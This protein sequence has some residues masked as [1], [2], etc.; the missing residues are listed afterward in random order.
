MAATAIDAPDGHFDLVVFAQSFHHLPPG[1]ASRVFAEGT[2]VATK[3]LIIDLPR[4]PS[5][6]HIAGLA[7]FLPLTAVHPFA[8]GFISSLRA[9]SPSAMRALARYA[10]PAIEVRLHKQPWG[11]QIVV[12]NRPR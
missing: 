8:H 10:D 6:P 5:I 11:R 4:P 12:A 9:Y 7:A 1:L 3:L 2:R